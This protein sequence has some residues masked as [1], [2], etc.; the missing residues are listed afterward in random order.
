MT[1]T[2]RKDYQ[3]TYYG[4]TLKKKRQAAAEQRRAAKQLDGVQKRLSEQRTEEVTE[5]T[6]RALMK[7]DMR[8]QRDLCIT[9]ELDGSPLVD[10][11]IE[12]TGESYLAW[13]GAQIRE[14]ITDT[15]RSLANY[16]FSALL[17]ALS[18]EDAGRAILRSMGIEPLQ[19]AGWGRYKF[20]PRGKDG[21]GM[22]R[23]ITDPPENIAE[24]ESKWN[25]TQG[26]A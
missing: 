24:L 2:S 8:R 10:E 16:D 21:E 11:I 22:I 9:Q 18:M 14:Y 4:T 6:Q 3:K 13:L 26:R 25:A 5:A 23:T 19:N 15:K 7:A 1:D 20:V 17:S 12:E